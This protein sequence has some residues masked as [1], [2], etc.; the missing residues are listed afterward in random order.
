MGTIM[1]GAMAGII[2]IT[3]I[4]AVTTVVGWMVAAGITTE[5]ATVRTPGP[6]LLVHILLV[7]VMGWV[8][9]DG[10]DESFLC[11]EYS[12]ARQGRFLPRNNLA[13]IRVHGRTMR[14][15]VA[16]VVRHVVSRPIDLAP[17]SRL[18]FRVS[19]F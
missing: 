18:H 4:V 15:S 1:L 11:W 10:V 14:E 9:E 17:E 2:T 12:P 8:V 16:L 6:S 13:R 19:G 7:R 3:T 5:Q